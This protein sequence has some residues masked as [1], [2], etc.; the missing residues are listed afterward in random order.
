MAARNLRLFA[1]VALSAAV[2]LVVLGVPAIGERFGTTSLTGAQWLAALALAGVAFVVPE[3]CKARPARACGDWGASAC[4][5]DP[6][7]PGPLLSAAAPPAVVWGAD[8]LRR[9][10]CRRRAAR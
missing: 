7:P 10:A 3:L 1:A 8:E 9:W 4:P 6:R 5:F 2:A